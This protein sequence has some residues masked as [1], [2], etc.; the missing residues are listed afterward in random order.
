MLFGCTLKLV[1]LQN[2][3]RDQL[4]PLDF[5]QPFEIGHTRHVSRF[6]NVINRFAV[7]FL[8]VT[9]E[10]QAVKLIFD[11]LF[12]CQRG[13]SIVETLS[14]ANETHVN[15]PVELTKIEG[16]LQCHL[17]I[18]NRTKSWKRQQKKKTYKNP[19]IIEPIHLCFLAAVA[20]TASVSNSNSLL[21]SFLLLILFNFH[22]VFICVEATEWEENCEKRNGTV[23][24][25][26]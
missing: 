11:R 20:S 13:I 9:E 14:N 3:L 21:F 5:R 15:W 17:Y 2:L 22:F 16:V 12:F 24:V 1:L 10:C 4:M 23:W 18:L 8:V 7:F 6:S 25:I 26:N 19:L